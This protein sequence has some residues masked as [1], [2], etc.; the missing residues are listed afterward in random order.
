MK[1]RESNV[2]V[3]QRMR[4]WHRDIGFFVIGLMTVYALSGIL[5]I[6]RNTDFLNVEKQV[7]TQLDAGLSAEALQQQLKLR[8]I[9]PIRTENNLIFFQNGS[10]DTQSGIATYTV[11]EKPF[12][13]NKLINL[14]KINGN[15]PTHL[16]SALFGIAVLFLVISSFWMFPR[17]SHFFKRG[18]LLTLGGVIF[19]VILLC[20]I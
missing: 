11:K 1:K 20:L 18:I 6:Y 2:T 4:A 15:Q 5:L 12:P 19:T 14:H 9:N 13:L 8:N 10:Y 16:F 7:E 17:Q 3:S